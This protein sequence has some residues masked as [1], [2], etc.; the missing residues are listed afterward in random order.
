MDNGILFSRLRMK[1]G[2]S[3][4]VLFFLHSLSASKASSALG[5]ERE[6]N[7]CSFSS[8]SPTTIQWGRCLRGRGVLSRSERSQLSLGKK[9]QGKGAD[10]RI[11]Q[12]RRPVCAKARNVRGAAGNLVLRWWKG[13]CRRSAHDMSRGQSTT[14]NLIPLKEI[15][16]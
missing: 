3:F 14:G 7:V 8:P 15:R 9:E 11:F 13:K 6:R 12:G 2:V 4:P 5:T 16:F 10:P 1:Q